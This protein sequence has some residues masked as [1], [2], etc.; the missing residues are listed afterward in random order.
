MD[1]TKHIISA[2][3]AGI[4]VSI[5]GIAYL[6]TGYAWLFPI[7]LYIVCF[8]GLDL[9][10]GRICYYRGRHL[11]SRY[12]LIYLFNTV[13]AYL[14]GVVIAYA[15]PGLVEKTQSLV[16]AKMVNIWGMIPLAVL[17]NV[18]IFVA[19]DTYKRTSTAFMGGNPLGLIFATT[20]F[21]ACGF[22]HCIANAFYFGVAGEFS[23]KGLVFLV[24]NMIWNGIGGIVACRIAEMT[25]GKART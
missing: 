2:F 13:A 22:E 21:V 4:A 23:A 5:G 24:V 10:T 18:C 25:K 17:C 3:A 8:Y 20:V 7:G 12:L 16:A 1:H 9:F 15:K 6:Q 19:V 11:L 14:T